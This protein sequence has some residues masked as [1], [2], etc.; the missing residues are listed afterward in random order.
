MKEQWQQLRDR[1]QHLALSEDDFI[2]LYGQLCEAR[3]VAIGEHQAALHVLD[4]C[5]SSDGTTMLRQEQTSEHASEL[6][7]YAEVETDL[8]AARQRGENATRQ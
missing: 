6:A 2:E 3:G 4:Q 7:L 8:R 5:L 1:L